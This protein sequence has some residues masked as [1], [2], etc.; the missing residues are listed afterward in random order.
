MSL[1]EM[2]DEMRQKSASRIPADKR[3]IMQAATSEL[4][5]SGIL[6]RLPKPGIPL[7]SFALPDQDGTIMNS[8][9]L[10]SRG[11]LVLCFYRGVW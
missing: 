5:E 8:D 3:A 10:T 11:P 1:Q 7:P 4:Q 2:L 6:D 9:H